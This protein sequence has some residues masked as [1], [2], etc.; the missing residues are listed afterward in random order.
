MWI[1]LFRQDIKRVG[2]KEGI[3]EDLLARYQEFNFGETYY[4]TPGDNI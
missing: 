2:G 4:A 3:I 1:L